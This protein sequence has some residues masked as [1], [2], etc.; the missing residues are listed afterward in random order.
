MK[1]YKY[2]IY[3]TALQ[4]E[5]LWRCFGCVRFVYNWGLWLSKERYLWYY[6]LANKLKQ[7]KLDNEW[8]K[9]CY[10][11]SLQYSLKQLDTAF[12][13]FFKEKYWYPKFKKKGNIQTL[14]YPQFVDISDKEIKIPKLWYI[15]CKFH[16]ECKWNIKSMTITKTASWKYYVSILTDYAEQKPSW[17]WKIGIDMWIKE[18]AILSN[19]FV[20]H[21]PK[22]LKKSQKRLK[23]LQRQMS[24]KKKWSSNRN[25]F[26]IRLAKQYEKVSNQRLDFHHK[27]SREIANQFGFVAMEKLNIKWMMDNH[28]LAN[29]IWD[30]GWYQFKTLLSYKTKVVEIDTFQPS[31]KT[32]SNCWNVKRTLS[33]DERV[34]RC[35]MCGHVEDRDVNAAKNILAIADVWN[36]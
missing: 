25:K 27:V 7:L 33:L 26:R 32:C 3:P 24:R 6:E 20:Y 36:F 19:G 11:Q 2:R 1:T 10:S 16:R 21:N 35:D 14:H 31:S 8:L 13:H 17:V 29:S 12:Q 28:K 15:R 5:S 4:Q 22:Y 34:Y 9:E 23:R 30:A 18:F